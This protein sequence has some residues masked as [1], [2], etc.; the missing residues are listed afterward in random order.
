MSDLKSVDFGLKDSD[1]GPISRLKLISSTGMA[2][3]KDCSDA[4]R[5]R[6]H[7]SDDG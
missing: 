2:N 3:S 7:E 4:S 5:K 1:S 6:Y